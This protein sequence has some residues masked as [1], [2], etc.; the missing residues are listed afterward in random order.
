MVA[1]GVLVCVA[2]YIAL[3]VLTVQQRIMGDVEDV[4]CRVARKSGDWWQSDL[5][6]VYSG[7]CK[8]R[9]RRDT[10]NERRSGT[11]VEMGKVEVVVERE[12]AWGRRGGDCVV[13]HAGR[14]TVGAAAVVAVVFPVEPFQ[15]RKGALLGDNIVHDAFLLAALESGGSVCRRGRGGSRSLFCQ[16]CRVED[17]CLLGGAKRLWTGQRRG[18]FE[19]VQWSLC[20]VCFHLEVRQLELHFQQTCSFQFGGV[21]AVQT[22]EGVSLDGGVGDTFVGALEGGRCASLHHVDA[23]CL[24]SDRGRVRVVSEERFGGKEVFAGAVAVAVVVVGDVQLGVGHDSQDWTGGWF[25]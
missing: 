8:L 22:G 20:L 12:D 4:G 21:L 3:V 11:I 16:F 2:V 15:I 19:L 23:M 24:A 6:P 17:G 1:D 25:V 9:R 7:D 10:G 18:E 13:L 14:V 5:F